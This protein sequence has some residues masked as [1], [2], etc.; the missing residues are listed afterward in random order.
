M[1]WRTP[2]LESG[3]RLTRAEF[4]ARYTFHPEIKKAELIE[5]VVYVASPVRICQHS[6]PHARIMTWITQYWAATPG[7]QV[8][9]SGTYRADAN[10]DPQPDVS[11]WIVHAQTGGAQIDE[12][13]YL[14][15]APELLVEVAASTAS[16]DLGAKKEVY[17]R[18]GVQKYL[19]LQVYEQQVSW[20]TLREG[21]YQELTADAEGILRSKVFPGLWF[22]PQK[23]W[24][25]DLAGLL[26]ILQQGL[27]S[28]EHSTFIEKLQP[29]S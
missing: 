12:D 3:D 22:D 13:D 20:F 14:I 15:G 26:A 29:S 21:V 25:G 7:V 10:N 6:V 28:T 1:G 5:G 23:F 4:E 2:P 17:R 27:T 19:V 8:A 18:S 11:L 24:A 9:D 16:L